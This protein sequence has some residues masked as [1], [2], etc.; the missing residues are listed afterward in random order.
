M[1]T[2]DRSSCF[3]REAKNVVVTDLFR[4]RAKKLYPHLSLLISAIPKDASVSQ[5]VLDAI[6]CYVTIQ[7][8]V[9]CI[10]SYVTC[11]HSACWS[12]CRQYCQ[13]YLFA[14]RKAGM[15]LSTSPAGST[16][17]AIR[18]NQAAQS[19]IR[20]ATSNLSFWNASAHQISFGNASLTARLLSCPSLHTDRPAPSTLTGPPPPHTLCPT[21][22]YVSGAAEIINNALVS[23]CLSDDSWSYRH[24]PDIVHLMVGGV[25]G[26]RTLTAATNFK[27]LQVSLMPTNQLHLSAIIAIKIGRASCRERV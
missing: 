3:R 13:S 10:F 25:F 4:E 14:H 15:M 5:T 26:A 8:R 19:I 23:A 20:D 9:N 27:F 16:A 11:S 1:Y 21:N 22:P 18:T 17:E 12:S 6:S 2:V 7:G 24:D